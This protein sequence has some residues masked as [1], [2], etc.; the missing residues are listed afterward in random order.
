MDGMEEIGRRIF[1]NLRRRLVE[2][3][4]KEQGNTEKFD[5]VLALWIDLQRAIYLR[6]RRDRKQNECVPWDSSDTRVREAW[7]AL[8]EP[9]NVL[10]LESLFY[11]LPEGPQMEMARHALQASRERRDGKCPNPPKAK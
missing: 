9:T 10:P 11:Q 3:T 5:R 4:M 6:E 1:R 7:D 8:T 2:E